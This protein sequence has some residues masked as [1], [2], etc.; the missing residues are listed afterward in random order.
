MFAGTIL[1]SDGGAYP[2][3][4][5]LTKDLNAAN[6]SGLVLGAMLGVSVSFLVPYLLSVADVKSRP[7]IAQ[8]ILV[9]II[10]IPLGCLA[11]GFVA[12]YGFIFMIKN[13]MPAILFSAVVA[14]GL[15]FAQKTMI[16]IFLIFGKCVSAFLIGSLIIA[17]IEGATGFVIIKGMA[18]IGES[19]VIIGSIIIILAGA[20]SLV[21]ILTCILRN[22]LKK[23]SN[24]LKINDKSAEGL[25]ASLATVIAIGALINDMDNKGK[26]LN[27]AFVVSA[28]FVF[29]DHLGFTAS[30][31]KDM[32]LAVVI[33]K[34]AGGIT[35]LILACI[36]FTQPSER[37]NQAS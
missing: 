32:I 3:A 29:G 15:I 5:S 24:F 11:G 8:G 4:L 33:G 1:S 9:G 17:A 6:F 16:K 22:P 30:V 28:G 2:M 35:A 26:I 13:L 27:A 36:I 19:F 14:I 20:F 25:F 21:Y 10:T 37:S 34:L 23:A 31:N 7:Y 12:G 18:P